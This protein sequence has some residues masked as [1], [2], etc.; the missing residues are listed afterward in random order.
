MTAGRTFDRVM[1][2]GDP[3]SGTHEATCDLREE[4]FRSESS[5]HG[6]YRRQERGREDRGDWQLMH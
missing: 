5:S 1:T 6:G 4:T 3:A 2:M